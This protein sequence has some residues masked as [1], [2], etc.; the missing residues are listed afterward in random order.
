MS[1]GNA[2][3][4]EEKT[5]VG[6]HVQLVTHE[7]AD[8]SLVRIGDTLVAIFRFCHSLLAAGCRV[9]TPSAE[10]PLAGSLGHADGTA[11]LKLHLQPGVVLEYL[12]H[13]VASSAHLSAA[14]LA[15]GHNL[16]QKAIAE[17]IHRNFTMGYAIAQ[18]LSHHSFHSLLSL[19]GAF[20]STLQRQVGAQGNST[21]ADKAAKRRLEDQLQ[22]AR[23]E[24]KYLRDGGTDGHHSQGYQSHS[25]GYQSQNY[26]DGRGGRGGRGAGRGP[27][28]GRGAGRSQA[29]HGSPDICYDFQRAAG[30]NRGSCKFLHARKYCSAPDHGGDACTV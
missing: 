25:Q 9:I 23:S 19:H 22:A 5:D 11:A 10:R 2:A 28:T 27:A 26:Q 8:A 16:F 18:I 21:P 7:A 13:A 17:Q 4:R 12:M 3:P 14:H 24:V 1:S 29:T 20:P 15:L 30:C 6:L